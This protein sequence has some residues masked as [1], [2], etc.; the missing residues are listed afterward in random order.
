M[1]ADTEKIRVSVNRQTKLIAKVRLPLYLPEAIYARL[2]SVARH[3][4]LSMSAK[5][6]QILREALK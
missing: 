5:V 3:G 1:S 2:E 4:G 6:V